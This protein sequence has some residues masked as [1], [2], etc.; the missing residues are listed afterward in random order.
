MKRGEICFFKVFF[1]CISKTL[2]ALFKIFCHMID[3]NLIMW[4]RLRCLLT[5]GIVVDKLGLCVVACGLLSHGVWVHHNWLCVEACGLLN[6]GVWVDHTWI[7]VVT[8]ACGLLHHG[9]WAHHTWIG[10]LSLIVQWLLLV[11]I[12]LRAW[13]STLVVILCFLS[14]TLEAIFREC[15]SQFY[16]VII[17]VSATTAQGKT[18]AAIL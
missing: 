3:S 18:R 16:E 9:V 11:V 4:H 13:S 14:L 5:W 2:N 15:L 1:S 10:L 17:V 8:L 6:H 7:G 12:K